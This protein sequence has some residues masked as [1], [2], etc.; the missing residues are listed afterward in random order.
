MPARRALV[1]GL[2]AYKRYSADDH[3]YSL[4]G[5]V[6]D[7]RVMAGILKDKFDFPETSVRLLLDDQA[8]K[9]GILDAFDDL[10]D[11]TGTDDVVVFYYAGHG[12]QLTWLQK[13]DKASGYTT[14]LCPFDVMHP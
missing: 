5:C 3:D 2:N 13:K 6:N 7:A 11:A 14:A 4:H 10:I 1:I 12:S 9:D 8:T